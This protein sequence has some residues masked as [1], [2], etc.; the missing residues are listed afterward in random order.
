[1]KISPV[2]LGFTV[3]WLRPVVKQIPAIWLYRLCQVNTA[4]A[5]RFNAHSK[6]FLRPVEQILSDHMS[7]EQISTVCREYLVHRRYLGHF[8]RLWQ[9][10]DIQQLPA[11]RIQGMNYLQDALSRGAGAILI[12]GHNY[13]FSRM[14]GPLLAR[15]GYSISRVGNLSL[16]IIERRWGTQASWEYIYIPEDPWKRLRALKQLTAALKNNRVIHFMILNRPQGNGHAEVEFFGRPFFLDDTT[17]ELISE[18]RAPIL[19]CFALCNPQGDIRIEIHARMS[20]SKDEWQRSWPW[21]ILA[22]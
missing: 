4:L 9:F 14:V 7:R 3:P 11:A 2:A 13:G 19:P 10:M 6:R 1:M 21:F 12:S 18:L 15:A 16:D 20:E 5:L 17:L 22:I 8:E